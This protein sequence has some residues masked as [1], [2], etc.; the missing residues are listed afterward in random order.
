MNN[1][2]G[3][4]EIIDH[5]VLRERLLGE[6][7]YDHK[8][9]YGTVVDFNRAH[10]QLTKKEEE[11]K[12]ST[13]VK[14]NF[15]DKFIDNIEQP[16]EFAGQTYY[17]KLLV[18]T[19]DY[20]EEGSHQK[21][22]VSTYINRHKS[23]IVSIRKGDTTS[24][25]VTC[26]FLGHASRRFAVVQKKMKYNKE[27]D[28]CFNIAINLVEDKFSGKILKD[29]IDE[30]SVIDRKTEKVLKTISLDCNSIPDQQLGQAQLLGLPF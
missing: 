18:D 2:I 8:I 15:K 28:E 5:I 12:S 6:Y 22:C 11:F 23:V 3:I 4:Q 14:R 27:P 16:I 26:E 10:F 21:H 24:E 20:I 25:R 9:R 29:V 17:P 13:Y 19:Y 7:D 30:V 1:G